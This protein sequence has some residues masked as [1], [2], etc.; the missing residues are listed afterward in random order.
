MSS[1]IRWWDWATRPVILLWLVVLLLPTTTLYA[2]EVRRS[3]SLGQDLG[4]WGGERWRLE[5]EESTF[6]LYDEEELVWREERQQQNGSTVI[7]RWEDEGE[8][9]TIT[10]LIDGIIQQKEAGGQITRYNYD[11]QQRLQMVSH[12]DQGEAVQVELYTYRPPH[13][14]LTTVIS[15][16]EDE[17]VRTFWHQGDERHYL[18]NGQE[19]SESY[20]SL[21]GGIEL[22]ERLGE[23][24]GEERRRLIPH[25]DGSF[26]IEGA[27]QSEYYDARGLLIEKRGPT[28]TTKYRYNEENTLVWTESEDEGGRTVTVE[29]EED[30]RIMREERSDGMLTKRVLWEADGSRIE[31]LYSFGKPYSDVSYAPASNKVRSIIYH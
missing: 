12:F 18:Y 26:L 15:L 19:I 1:L 20:R 24:V 4:E 7:R 27:D 9:P 17:S 8:M 5:R 28:S 3:N 16:G 6:S 2:L 11:E 29:Y 25:E 10:L 31:T 13:S 14:A 30:G 22:I 21:A 23:G